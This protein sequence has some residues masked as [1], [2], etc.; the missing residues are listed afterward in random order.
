MK[1]YFL[2]LLMFVQTAVSQEIAIYAPGNLADRF[3][4]GA[5]DAPF[6]TESFT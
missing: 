2:L 3:G 6:T 4:S 5:S 1:Y